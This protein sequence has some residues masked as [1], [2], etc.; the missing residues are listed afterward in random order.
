M[1]RLSANAMLQLVEDLISSKNASEVLVKLQL[2]LKPIATFSDMLILTQDHQQLCALASTFEPLSG[3]CLLHSNSLME[4]VFENNV[5]VVSSNVLP[6]DWQLPQQEQKIALVA[7][8]FAERRG[9]YILFLENNKVDSAQ[10]ESN[11]LATVSVFRQAFIQ[12]DQQHQTSQMLLDRTYALTQSQQR[13]QAYAELASDWFWETDESMCFTYLSFTEQS[14]PS[15]F[16]HFLHKSPLN[17]RSDSESTQFKKWEHFLHLVRQHH[18]ILDFEFEAIDNQGHRVWISISGKAKYNADGSFAGYLGIAKDISFAKQRESDLKAAKEKAESANTAKSHFLA[19]MSHEIRTPMNAI[20]G[21]LELLEDTNPN[22]KQRELIDFMRGSAQLLQGVI[23][24][25]LDFAKIE[26]GTLALENSNVNL[27]KLIKNLVQQFET[28]ALK[29]GIHF[30]AIL[31]NGVPEQINTDGVRLSQVLL[32]LLGNAFKFTLEGEVCLAVNRSDTELLISVK[33]SGIGIEQ[34]QIDTLFEPFSQLHDKQV[35]R[36]Q[37]VG[38]GLSI[39][40]RLLELMKG[41]IECHSEIGVG[42]EFSVAIPLEIEIVSTNSS[43][44]ANKAI[45]NP[46]YRILVAEDN[47][48]NQFIIKAIL[49]KRN[50]TVSL[51]D[52]GEKAVAA[53]KETQFDLVLMDMVMPVMDG[54]TAARTIRNELGEMAPPIIA[55]TANAGLADKTKCLNAGMLDVLTKPLNSALLDEKIKALFRT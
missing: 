46:S 22:D 1:E 6:A 23:S 39:T 5:M 4:R 33:D 51:A 55:L 47:P 2:G 13:F 27:H 48:A 35:G 17:I 24:D 50:H 43:G 25:T 20:L 16:A 36:Q 30:K 38:L 42:T 34:S 54:V 32:N 8:N 11:L 15:N 10:L 31:G 49:E 14:K 9:M 41:K 18:E 37:G 28:Q 21:I 52:N 40:K 26:S 45:D 29:K 12:L 3:V 19:V 53:V 44:G 7:N